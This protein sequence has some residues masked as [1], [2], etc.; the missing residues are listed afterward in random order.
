LGVDLILPIFEL[1]RFNGVESY[2][3]EMANF[4][5]YEKEG[6]TEAVFFVTTSE[7]KASLPDTDELCAT[8]RLEVGF[9]IFEPLSSVFTAGAKYLN[10]PEYHEDI[11]EW[12]TNLYYVR[13]QGVDNV[14]VTIESVDA[15][16]VTATIEGVT[17]DINFYDRSKPNTT[18]FVR[19]VFQ[20]QMDLVKTFG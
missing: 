7:C 4:N 10:L 17:T 16:T 6:S 9:K 11:D 18:V 19:A 3:V 13:H 14:S 8:P 15:E 2:D 20:R 12:M 5:V 1:R